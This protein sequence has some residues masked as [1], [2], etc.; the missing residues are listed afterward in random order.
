MDLEVAAGEV[1]A[2]LGPNGAGKS[3]LLRLAAGDLRPTGGELR[4]LGTPP[5]LP[6][7]LLRRVGYAP[8]RPVHFEVLSGGE[9]ARFFARASGLAA[10]PAGDRVSELLTS[11]SLDEASDRPA[12]EYSD[13]MRRKLLLI[14]ALAARPEIVLLDEALAGLDPPSIRAAAELLR[15]ASGEGA[16]VLLATQAVREAR[17]LADRIVFLHRGRKV[18]DAPPGTLM[19]EAGGGETVEVV[20]DRPP[21]PRL[22]LPPG[23]SRLD[24]GAGTAR[25]S[26]AGGS[27]DLPDLL[28]VLVEAGSV[29]REVRLREP[30]LADVFLALTGRE[31]KEDSAG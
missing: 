26:A 23:V 16:A 17:H 27:R 1:V 9:N 4:I 14:E 22:E 15:R 24:A 31:L 29:I 18:A 6:P 3:T 13:G 10:G 25:F 21:P 28:G 8:P 19:A 7:A 5:P 30:D 2:L 20:T 11:L 12:G